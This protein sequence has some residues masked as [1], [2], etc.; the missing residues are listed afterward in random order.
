[1]AS[2]GV[3]QFAD[4]AGVRDG[5]FGPG[6]VGEHR[7]ILDLVFID[8]GHR[9]VGVRKVG[10]IAIDPRANRPDA[11]RLAQNL[12]VLAQKI[13]SES[14]DRISTPDRAAIPAAVHANS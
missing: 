9:K 8:R 11:I 1:M 14:S 7:E 13:R 2:N 4:F 6:V 5:R 12:R 3:G 10:R